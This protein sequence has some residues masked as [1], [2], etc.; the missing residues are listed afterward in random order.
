MNNINKDE[1]VKNS[2]LEAAKRVFQK[3]GL[4][5]TTMEDIAHEAGKGK[6]TLYYYY[7]SKDEIFETLAISEL[8][9]CIV[10]ANFS[11]SGIASAKEKL[12]KYIAVM[13]GEIKKTAS[14]YP[15]V[16]GEIKGDKEFL[17]M[18]RKQLHEKEAS[19][20]T[21]ILKS[22]LRSGEFHF[23]DETEVNKVAN[24]IVS[25]LRGLLLY[26]F[27]ENDDNEQ[28]DIVTRLISEGI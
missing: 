1:E 3:W 10:K 16:T 12:R 25:V 19:I 21:E 14:I 23:L 11:V 15:L 5:K 26:L 22:G 13:L 8:N 6:S 9:N 27:L 20:V 24:V 18:V 7:K 28:I 4:N 2:I 17:D